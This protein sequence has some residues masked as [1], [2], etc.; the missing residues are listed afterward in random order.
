[1]TYDHIYLIGFLHKIQA[2]PLEYHRV[3]IVRCVLKPST[4]SWIALPY[5]GGTCIEY[6]EVKTRPSSR[7]V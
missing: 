2:I 4:P 1:M 6:I 3:S 7:P 5:D